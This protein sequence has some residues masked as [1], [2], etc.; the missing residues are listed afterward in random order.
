MS[1]A[2]VPLLLLVLALAI[3]CSTP[4]RNRVKPEYGRREFERDLAECRQGSAGATGPV[5]RFQR[6]WIH[7]E[8]TMAS[9]CMKARGWYPAGDEPAADKPVD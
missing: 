9:A 6:A 4:Y 8:D 5:G 2:R 3:A 1:A 7:A